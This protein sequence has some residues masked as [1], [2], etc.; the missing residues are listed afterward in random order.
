M[1]LAELL[2]KWFL[3]NKELSDQLAVFAGKPAIF[4]QSTPA[5]NQEGW[6]AEG[7]YPRIV[8]TIDM[9]A[10]QERKSAGA[11]EISLLC[12]ETG[13]LPE[14]IE[15]AVKGCLKDLL[16]LP[17]GGFPYCFTWARSEPF[18]IPVRE[19]GTDTRIVGMEL[20]FDIQEYTYQETTDPDPVAAANQYL[21]ELYPEYL[22]IGKDRMEE[23]TKA[24][25][26][27][28]V[29]Y[30]RL[31]DV[32]RMQETN[33]VVWMDGKIAVHILCP[34]HGI[35]MKLAADLAKRLALD[36]EIIMLDHSPMRITRL[37]ADYTADY[38]TAG[39]LY[40]TARYGLLRYREKKHSLT[41]GGV[42]MRN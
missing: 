1:T 14:D 12:D 42:V 37:Q 6:G 4:F 33:T 38:L 23:I 34:D 8:Y 16:L 18:E 7:Q 10:D 9:Q 13:I 27:K 24:T 26:E 3:E 29:I 15:P 31:T 36:G 30:C 2:H 41:G 17:E 20:R 11:M 40:I 5:D 21:K 22:V 39:L 19:S 28:P 25:A 32:Q 35:R